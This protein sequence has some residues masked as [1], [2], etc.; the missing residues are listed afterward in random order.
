MRTLSHVPGLDPVSEKE[1]EGKV[2]KT[3][4]ILGAAWKVGVYREMFVA[5]LESVE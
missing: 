2:K 3:E 4:N 5:T 1:E